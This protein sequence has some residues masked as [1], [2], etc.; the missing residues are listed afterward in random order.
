[1]A[2]FL[3]FVNVT[4]QQRPYVDPVPWKLFLS[5]MDDATTIPLT[6]RAGQVLL[7]KGFTGLGVVPIELTVGS[8][9]GVAGGLVRGVEIVTRDIA[10]PVK[11]WGNTE[12]H[13]R[14]AVAA[15]ADLTDPDADMTDA[16]NFK[17]VC[18]S[19]SGTRE[20]VVAYRGGLEDIL[21][22][23]PVPEKFVLDLLATNPYARDQRASTKTFTLGEGEPFLTEE[24]SSYVWPRKL[25][26]SRVS[27][28]GITLDMAS[29]VKV[30]PTLTL[31]GP[32]TSAL[33]TT[34]TGLRIDVPGGL[35]VGQTLQIVTDPRGR[36]IRMNGAQAAGRL[37]LSSRLVPFSRGVNT[38]SVDAPGATSATKL[39]LEWRG[40]HRSI[41]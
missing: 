26:S 33:I 17:V 38:L 20:I 24:G 22:G 7:Q 15:L 16:G 28:S 39:T 2:N 18:V 27:G 37:S 34:D 32:F 11:V 35:T 36:S 30:Y 25:S 23:L 40:Q 41:L 13:K 21:D 14:E 31:R 5:S 12:M 29:A 4:T 3:V 19:P 1:M 6:D 9:P 10:L 8:T